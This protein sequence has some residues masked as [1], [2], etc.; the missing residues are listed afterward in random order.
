VQTAEPGL[1]YQWDSKFSGFAVPG[2]LNG[3]G[4]VDPTPIATHVVSPDALEGKK[5]NIV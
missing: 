2:F 1:K 4:M 5:I 3:L